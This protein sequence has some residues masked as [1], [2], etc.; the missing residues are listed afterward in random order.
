MTQERCRECK[1]DFE[2]TQRSPEIGEYKMWS[3]K[4][5]SVAV[6][7]SRNSNIL[8]AGGM[9]VAVPAATCPADNLEV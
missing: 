3:A 9:I 8:A 4:S 6:I 2:V 1:D 7:V 5:V